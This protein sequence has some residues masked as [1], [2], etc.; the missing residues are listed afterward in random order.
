MAT[1]RLQV[2]YRHL[3]FPKFAINPTSGTSL[4]T[5]LFEDDFRYTLNNPLLSYEQRKFYEEN[6][7]I[8]IPKLIEDELLDEC[9]RRFADYCNGVI[10]KGGITMMKDISLMKKGAQ[11]EFLYNKLQDIL[12]DS[13]FEKYFFH[14]KLLEYV[15]CFTGPNIKGM[16]SMLINKPPDSGALTS[17]H[18]LHQDL[19]YFPFRPA[20]RIVASWTAMERITESNGCLVVLPGT[21]KGELQPHDY[22]KWEGGV[23]KAYHGI[24]GYDDYPTVPLHMEKGDTVFFHPLLIH[25]SGANRTKGFRKAISCHFS[26]ADYYFIDVKG[27]IQEG[28]AKEIEEMAI[29]KGFPVTI[30]EIWD[31]KGRIMKADGN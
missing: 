14:P 16:H 3:S 4:N 7:Y 30:E 19:Y 12:Y 1:D 13:V 2:I 21:H 5:Q 8:V 9:S 6:G 18:P 15:S 24:L 27:T 10:P 17:R 22:P 25:G 26:T 28:I 20:D 31:L 11:G 29:K 23:N